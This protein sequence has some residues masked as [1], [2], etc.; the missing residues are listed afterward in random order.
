MDRHTDTVRL[1]ERQ[2]EGQTHRRSQERKEDL[3]GKRMVE[4]LSIAVKQIKANR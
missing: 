1:T 4:I 3:I 2:T